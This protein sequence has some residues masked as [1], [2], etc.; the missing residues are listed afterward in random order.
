M[1]R[2]SS[3]LEGREETQTDSTEIK[4]TGQTERN[5]TDNRC[6]TADDRPKVYRQAREYRQRDRQQT[7]KSQQTNS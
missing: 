6:Q 2:D 5:Y 1:R 3:L 4:Q 7:T